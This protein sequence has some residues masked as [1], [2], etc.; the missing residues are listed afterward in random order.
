MTTP[1]NSATIGIQNGT[2]TM[3]LQVNYNAD[4]LHNHMAVLLQNVNEG[5]MPVHY[6]LYR[7]TST[8][9]PLAP[10]NLVTSLITGSST[11]YSDTNGLVNGTRY[12]YA[13]VSIWPDSMGSG[14][15]NEASAIPLTGARM[16]LNPTE[17]NLSVSMGSAIL[18]TINIAN[19]G[20]LNLSWNLFAQSDLLLSIPKEGNS[21]NASSDQALMFR[22]DASGQS[23]APPMLFG[24]GGP[25]GFGYSW[26][27]SDEPGGPSYHWVDIVGRGQQITMAN[28]ANLGPYDMGFSFP[29]YGAVFDSLRICSNGW[30]SF[31]STSTSAANVILPSSSAPQNLIAPFW[32]DLDPSAGGQVWY[33]SNADSAVVTWLGVPHRTTGG[34][35]TVQVVLL[36]TGGIYFNYLDVADP[37][38]SATIGIQNA[39]RTT[40]LQIVFNQAYVHDS[41][42]VKIVNSW[43]TA[44]PVLGVVAPGGNTNITVSCD[45]TDLAVGT[46]TGSLLIYGLDQFHFLPLVTAPVTLHVTNVD[47]IGDGV[48]TP[49]R[50]ELLQNYPNPF[51]PTTEIGFALPEKA[52]V[53][54][55]IYNVLGQ[56]TR[57]LINA[58]MEAGINFVTWNGADDAGS[59]VASG[60]YF[61]KLVADNN[62]IIKKMTLLK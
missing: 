37:I 18:D 57:T 17:L 9:V 23:D 3:G 52:H 49:G 20:G 45:A 36:A 6:N 29:F 14:P 11:S 51:N 39:A 60:I 47:A 4:Y 30:V 12:Y 16:T 24:R 41:L 42:S 58:D 31:T 5:V 27:D 10:G 44:T 43:L 13:L 2:G 62:V 21:D 7:A 50:F 38:N 25:D 35:Y 32:D 15:S 54:L 1:L 19:P 40:A 61:Y 56:K 46:Y 33:Y 34:P 59:P 8:P 53:S 55:D 22:A 48:S 28:D 26:I